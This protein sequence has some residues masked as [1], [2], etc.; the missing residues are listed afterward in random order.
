[1]LPNLPNLPGSKD[2]PVPVSV[3]DL[4]SVS[5]SSDTNKKFGEISQRVEKSKGQ[6][7]GRPTQT[8][9]LAMVEGGGKKKTKETF[10]VDF[11]GLGRTTGTRDYSR[12]T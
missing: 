4:G 1:M 7:R 2:S 10:V 11:P 5:G 12:Q 3:L 8:E 9:R 6:E